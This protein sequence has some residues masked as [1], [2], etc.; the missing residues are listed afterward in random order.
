MS[1]LEQNTKFV[2]CILQNWNNTETLIKHKAFVKEIRE[3]SIMV[4]VLNRSACSHC[5]AQNACHL[6]EMREKEIEV[7]YRGIKVSAG[8]EVTVVLRELSGIKA[9]FF[10]YLFPFILVLITLI[11][12][13][14]ITGNELLSG[15]ISIGI[16]I[17]YYITLYFLRD[18]L[19]K[20]FKF[21]LEGIY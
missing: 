5:H 14:A 3:N 8:Q 7:P 6:S 20:V 2:N 9:L 18:Y 12:V 11:T 10:G 1:G 4:T 19:K 17:P 16:L 13:Y 15:V 21:E